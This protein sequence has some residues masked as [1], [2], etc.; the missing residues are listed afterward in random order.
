MQQSHSVATYEVFAYSH[1]FSY[2]G[3]YCYNY[4]GGRVFLKKSRVIVLMGLF[5]ALDVVASC[6]LTIK[7]PVL[8]VGVSFIP[9]SFTGIIFGPLLGGAGAAIA[10]II[11]CF[12]YPAGAYIPGITI[13][14]FLSGAVYGLLLHGKRPSLWRCLIA[15]AIIRLVIGALLTTFWL[16]LAIP[17]NTFTALL[18]TRLPQ[19][20]VMLPVET[21]VIYTVWQVSQR[22][23]VFSRY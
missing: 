9:V 17:G 1:G 6:F 10:D 16:Y 21:I 22:T 19:C 3:N 15:A 7:T 23:K 11:Q 5:I 2:C 8:S 14:A 4:M 20:L 18:I 13:D 12:L